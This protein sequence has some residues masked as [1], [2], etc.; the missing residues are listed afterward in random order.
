MCRRYALVLTKVTNFD[1]ENPHFGFDNQASV[2][3]DKLSPWVQKV[4]FS[5]FTRTK[6]EISLSSR[7]L[8]FYFPLSQFIHV[9]F[10]EVRT[11]SRPRQSDLCAGGILLHSLKFKI[12]TRRAPGRSA[13]WGGVGVIFVIL[14]YFSIFKSFRSVMTTAARYFVR[15]CFY[16]PLCGSIC[17]MPLDVMTS[18]STHQSGPCAGDTRWF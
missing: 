5:K 8:G 18:S 6:Y 12:L 11:S 10:L 2:I 7:W 14:S 16:F 13:L 3:Q 15:V 17:M 4:K 1:G 9:V